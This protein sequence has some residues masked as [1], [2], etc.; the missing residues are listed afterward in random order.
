MKDSNILIVEDER[1]VALSIKEIL[2][3][4]GYNVCGIA[5]SAKNA[6]QIVASCKPGLVIM[7]VKI[8]GAMDGINLA[9][10]IKEKYHISSI[11]LTAYSDEDLLN[12][13][14]VA[15]PLGYI[16]KPFKPCDIVSA[17]KVAL[18]RYDKETIRD[19]RSQELEAE[20]EKR[21]KKLRDE[22][23]SRKQAEN[24]VQQKS[25]Y[26]QEANKAL[27]SLLETREAEQRAYKE[28]VLLNVRKYVIPYVE[29]IKSQTSDEN[30]LEIVG[31]LEDALKNAATPISKTLFAKYLDLTPQESKIADLIRQGKKTKEIADILNLAIS[32]VSTH[33]YSI[34]KKFGLLN[35]S[36]N[37]ETYLN[38]TDAKF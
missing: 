2:L 4:E 13:A 22:I 3:S 20:V 24:E 7:D 27:S 37:L 16:L 34:R 25:D 31:F 38:S 28:S 30:V 21:T 6:L 36:T 10:L 17:V 18:Y 19:L 32:S 23:A 8:K 14:K 15:E 26:L 29:M 9:K 33:R 11:F 1:I 35:S 5:N 12:R